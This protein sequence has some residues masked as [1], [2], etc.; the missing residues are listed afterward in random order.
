MR[1]E[2]EDIAKSER[3]RIAKHTSA[4]LKPVPA[5]YVA[6]SGVSRSTAATCLVLPKAWSVCSLI[7]NWCFLSVAFVLHHC[8]GE[9]VWWSSLKTFFLSSEGHRA[10]TLMLDLLA[11]S[12]CC[13]GMQF[14]SVC[15]GRTCSSFSSQNAWN[16]YTRIRAW[17]VLYAVL[18]EHR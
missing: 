16:L 13:F 6:L 1:I 12:K 2:C 10:K 11:F 3:Y 4:L 15:S 9:K 18:C 7:Q 14:R 5:M 17:I 8:C